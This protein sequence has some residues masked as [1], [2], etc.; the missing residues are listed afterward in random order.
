[1]KLSSKIV[2]IKIIY[3]IF[4]GDEK[5]KIEYHILKTW[6]PLL[7]VEMLGSRLT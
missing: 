4:I 1:M 3:Y 5:S 2:A 6:L 7:L